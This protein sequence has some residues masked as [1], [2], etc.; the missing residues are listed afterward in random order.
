MP[1]CDQET[2]LT[3]MSDEKQMLA[4]TRSISLK[5]GGN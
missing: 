2:I 3:Q 1:E 4:T 5:L